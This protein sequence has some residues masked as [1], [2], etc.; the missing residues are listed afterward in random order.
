M[1]ISYHKW[2]S[3]NLNRE[4]EYKIYGHQGKPVLVFPTSCGRFYQFED[5][6]MLH[7]VSSFVESG[8]IQIWACD[9]I[10]EETFFSGQ[11]TIED[12]ISRHNQYDQYISQELIPSVLQT[13]REN[14]HGKDQKVL[15]TG[16]SMGAYHGAN[17]FFRYPWLFDSV[18]ALSG[19]YS[20]NYF[21][22]DYRSIPVY[23]HSP[24]HYLQNLNDSAYLDQYRESKLI[25]C[26][27]QGAY[28][29]EMMLET[30]ELNR[31]LKGKSI[32]AWF[33]FW[34]NDVNHDWP[35]WQKQLPYYLEKCLFA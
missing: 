19:V 4:M 11:G 3:R 34:G 30:H 9:G 13:S 27:G 8:Q 21:F 17:F 10:D 31:V 5:S 2:Y 14:N 26:C 23:M 32:P 28:E 16:F 35:W 22:G 7:S 1:N 24:I 25:F 33:D 29:D 18:I 12:R 15:A 6:G 20:T